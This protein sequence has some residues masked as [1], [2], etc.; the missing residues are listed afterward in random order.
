MTIS[1]AIAKESLKNKEI[2][3]KIIKDV[4]NNRYLDRDS[5]SIEEDGQDCR[6]LSPK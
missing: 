2:E 3:S 1:Y 5:A 4:L 6:Y